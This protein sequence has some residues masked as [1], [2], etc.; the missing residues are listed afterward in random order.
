MKQYVELRFQIWKRKN[1]WFRRCK[2]FI[3]IAYSD[4]SWI[5]KVR[6]EALQEN[7]LIRYQVLGKETNNEKERHY[8]LGSQNNVLENSTLDR[9]VTTK[10]IRRSKR[11]VKDTFLTEWNK[12]MN[13]G[14]LFVTYFVYSIF[15]YAIQLLLLLL[16][17]NTI[18]RL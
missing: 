1:I 11:S 5:N 3:F 9:V 2:C 4:I 10:K 13:N 7:I 8:L 12:K 17:I 14:S 6:D 15:D 16:L 18:Q